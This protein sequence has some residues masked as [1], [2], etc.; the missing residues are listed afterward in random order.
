MSYK[1]IDLHIYKPYG[2]SY[3]RIS[4]VGEERTRKR[5]SND[6]L[7]CTHTDAN[8]HLS[9]ATLD[10]KNQ[11]RFWMTLFVSCAAVLHGFVLN[12]CYLKCHHGYHFSWLHWNVFKIITILAHEIVNNL[13][14]KSSHISE[15]STSELI[16]KLGKA[17]VISL[18]NRRLKILKCGRLN[19]EH[20][21]H[22]LQLV[23]SV[24]FP[25][26]IQWIRSRPKVLYLMIEK[27]QVQLYCLL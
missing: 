24:S 12:W 17:N 23:A 27:L 16:T 2:K 25:V 19:S 10:L 1:K 21:S 11:L 9:V 26:I 3:H 18:K 8:I 15:S 20:Q 5:D 14:M 4:D 7:I 6:N 13:L 22:I